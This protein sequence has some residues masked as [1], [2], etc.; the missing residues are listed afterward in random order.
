VLL[1]A[2]ASGFGWFH[3]AG[4]AAP[5]A[6]PAGFDPELARKVLE[7]Y[8]DLLRA[9]YADALGLARE[10]RAAVGRF[11]DRP[12]AE[13]L[14]DCKRAWLRARPAYLQSEI[15]RFYEGP[16]D[17]GTAPPELRLNAWPLDEAY[18]DY[19]EGNASSGLI[20][21]P[22]GFPT[23]DRASLRAAH[24]RGGETH[25]TL[26][27]HAIEFLLWGQDREIG[28]GGGRRSPLDY[29]PGGGTAANEGRRGAALRAAVEVLV[30]DL[31]FVAAQW[32]PGDPNGYRTWFLATDARQAL[33]KVMT[34]V[35]SM[36]YGELRG[37]RLVVPYTL[38]DRE[39]E[40]SCFSDTTHLDHLNDLLGIRNVWTGR[41]ESSDGRNDVAGTGLRELA[42]RADPPGARALEALLEAAVQ[43]A[44]N[45]A[46][47]PFEAAI[48][49]EDSSPGR[50]AILDLIRR[51]SSFNDAFFRLARRL[52]IP[53]TTVH[54][55]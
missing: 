38:K 32:T 46:L 14:E 13:G 11:L 16:I 23:V 40:H 29:V 42:G 4:P 9:T 44:R 51:L 21:D 1:A 8:A 52:G 26:G 31:E 45:P 48:Q 7:S 5:L 36:A 43:A 54:Q 53:I 30:E 34:G 6:A 10:L 20:N 18:L 28:P 15:A 27:W 37:E 12:S 41:Y 24:E 33:S 39:E 3:R 47:N 55:K 25:L 49:G 35:G 22:A 17:G 19:V 50:R 2:A